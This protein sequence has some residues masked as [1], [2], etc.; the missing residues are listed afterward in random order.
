MLS[1]RQKNSPSSARLT[2]S[3][4]PRAF[5]VMVSRRLTAWAVSPASGTSFPAWPAVRLWMYPAYSSRAWLRRLLLSLSL[6]SATGIKVNFGMKYPSNI[7]MSGE[8]TNRFRGYHVWW[9]AIEQVELAESLGFT[10]VW[11]VEHHFLEQL[12]SSSAPEVWLTAVAMRTSTMRIGHGVVLM[13]SK[14]NHPIRIAERIAALDIVSNGRVEFGM[15]RGSSFTELNGFEV[16]PAESRDMVLESVRMIP[17]MW[18]TDSFSHEGRFVSV[19]S[20]NVIPK[21]IQRPHPPMWMAC[22]QDDTYEIAWDLGLGALCFSAKSPEHIGERAKAY[23]ERIKTANPAG[24]FVNEQ[25]AGFA[26]MYFAD[27]DEAADEVA[28]P[29]LQFFLNNQARFFGSSDRA[30]HRGAEHN[31]VEETSESGKPREASLDM[32]RI[33]EKASRDQGLCVGS[34]EA[35]PACSSAMRPTASTGRYL[36]PSPARS[37]TIRSRNRCGRSPGTSCRRLP[38]FRKAPSCALPRSRVSRPSGRWGWL[39]G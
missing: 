12:S 14:I 25:V 36:S 2:V 1:S 8:W 13:P 26:M 17:K 28:G 31:F 27:T 5:A 21:P 37:A 15:G 9:E 7:F 32:H 33:L 3:V 11:G 23:R 19:P 34:P 24:A 30:R 20:R 29:T 38:P 4:T 10:H 35:P 6:A 22:G 39:A 18:A 16:D